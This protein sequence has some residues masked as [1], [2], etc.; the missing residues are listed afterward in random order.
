MTF[1]EASQVR[2]YIGLQMQRDARTNM[3][4]VVCSRSASLH[5]FLKHA[6]LDV[7]MSVGG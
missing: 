6:C 2:M 5:V 4:M 7:G 3:R 1:Q